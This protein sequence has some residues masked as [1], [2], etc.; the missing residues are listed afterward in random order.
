MLFRCFPSFE[1]LPSEYVAFWEKRAHLQ[2]FGNLEWFKALASLTTISDDSLRLYAA[3]GLTNDGARYPLGMFPVYE[4]SAKFLLIKRRSLHSLVNYYSSLYSPIIPQPDVHEAGDNQ[5]ILKAVLQ[6]IAAERPRWDVVTFEPLADDAIR[7][8][9]ERSLKA[10]GFAVFSYFRFWNWYLV[11]EGRTFEEYIKTV[12]K[13]VV[14]TIHRKQRKLGRELGFEVRIISSE[15]GEQD[16]LEAKSAYWQVFR[17]S[18]KQ[19]EPYEQFIDSLIDLAAS[20]EWLRL[21]VVYAENTPIAVQLWF[22]VD[23]VAYIYK[24]AY[25]ENYAKYSPGSILTMKMF[26]SAIDEDRVSEID[27]LTGDDHYKKDWMSHRRQ[28]L[29]LVGYNRKTFLGNLLYYKEK[30]WRFAKNFRKVL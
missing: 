11:L 2:L 25:D 17:N 23:G 21:G 20:N 22:V 26:E 18:W 16:L 7:C 28:R 1:A 3:E 5:S 9:L 24:L 6:G 12:P 27:Y 8:D 19:A 15:H 13:R 10:S 29:G 30:A 4:N 14:N